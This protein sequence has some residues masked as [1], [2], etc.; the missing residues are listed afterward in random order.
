V[1]ILVN[2]R[3]NALAILGFAAA[4][5]QGGAAAFPTASTPAPQQRN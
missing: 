2:F 5:C 1:Q 3:G 4:G